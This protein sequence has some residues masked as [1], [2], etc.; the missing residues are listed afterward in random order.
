MAS[1]TE[2]Y[3]KNKWD[4]LT[5]DLQFTVDQ[6][7]T[8]RGHDTQIGPAF[9][10]SRVFFKREIGSLFPFLHFLVASLSSIFYWSPWV[11]SCFL[12][13]LELLLFLKGQW[14][15]PMKGRATWHLSLSSAFSTLTCALTVPGLKHCTCFRHLPS[16]QPT[17]CSSLY[18]VTL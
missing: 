4:A 2:Y 17:Y 13:R 11:K 1:I 15:L 6:V 12:M 9:C 18:R 7:M 8:M 10:I 14:D 5:S 3:W 16:S